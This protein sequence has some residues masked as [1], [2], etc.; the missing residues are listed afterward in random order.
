MN[1]VRCELY[2]PDAKDLFKAFLAGGPQIE[3]ELALG[4]PLDW[5]ELPGKK[6]ARIRVLHAFTFADPSTWAEAFQWLSETA[7]K[8][9]RVFGR[10]WKVTQPSP[11][12]DGSKAA[13]ED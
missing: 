2:I 5:Q 8:F 10:D 3:K 6:A 12:G 4:T 9:K 11:A 7:I 1:Q 13:T